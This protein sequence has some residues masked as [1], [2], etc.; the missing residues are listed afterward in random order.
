MF[1]HPIP[2]GFKPN[3]RP[4][5]CFTWTP[6][7][8]RRL[9]HTRPGPGADCAQE[10]DRF[11]FSCT[12]EAFPHRLA[13]LFR[14]LRRLRR[15]HLRHR[16]LPTLASPPRRAFGG[17]IRILRQDL[18]EAMVGFLISQNN[19]IARIT[20]SMDLLR[21]RLGTGLPSLPR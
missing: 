6:P 9:A 21:R 18:W 2:Y 13:R 17:G 3:R 12:E 1:T 5:Q 4:G 11:T 8:R 20:R 15:V 10:G 7:A 19:N 16:P 14:S